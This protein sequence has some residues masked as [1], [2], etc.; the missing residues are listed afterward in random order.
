MK[1]TVVTLYDG[2]QCE[3]FV[4]VVVGS[5]SDDQ[6]KK[7]A[8]DHEA[9]YNVEVDPD[10]DTEDRRV[11]SFVEVDAM[12]DPDDLTVLRNIDDDAEPQRPE[13]ARGR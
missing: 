1:V 5:V 13:H 2:R 10:D 4:G 9:F 7:L 8:A 6:R 12:Q 3:S 11:L